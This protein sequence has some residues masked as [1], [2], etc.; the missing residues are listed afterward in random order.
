MKTFVPTQLGI[1]AFVESN[2][3]D[4]VLDGPSMENPERC[5]IYRNN[6]EAPLKLESKQFKFVRKVLD[7][8]TGAVK[9]IEVKWGRRVIR[10]GRRI[11]APGAPSFYKGL[12]VS[13]STA[14]KT[15]ADL[16]D[17]L[18]AFGA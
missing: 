12:E 16:A 13:N 10:L 5:T 14:P 9:Q 3:I 8:E 7:E 18:G 6:P 15:E 11:K 4:F 2:R 1:T 17:V